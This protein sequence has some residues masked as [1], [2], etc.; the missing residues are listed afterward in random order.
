MAVRYGILSSIEHF[1]NVRLHFIINS[2]SIIRN[3]DLCLS[4]FPASANPDG[5]S[6]RC[7]F[8]GIIYQINQHL[9]HQLHIHPGK[10]QILTFW[11]D[12]VFIMLTA[13]ML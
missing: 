11:N 2:R 1:K 13:D 3:T 6:W 7:I 5:R 10:N 8:D 4:I 9:N 12:L